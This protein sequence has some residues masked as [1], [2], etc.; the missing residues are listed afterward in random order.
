MKLSRTLWG[1]WAWKPFC[2]PHFLFIGN[3]LP[4]PW[5]SLSPKGQ[6]QRVANRDG[7]GCR[8]KRLAAKKQQCRLGAGSWLCLKE[9]TWYLWTCLQNWKF[10]QM[11]DVNLMKHSFQKEGHSLITSRT[12]DAYQETTWGQIKEMQWKWK[13]LSPVWL[14]DPMDCSL[15]GSSVHGILQARILEWVAVPFCRGPS[16]PRSLSLQVDSLPSEPDPTQTLMLISNLPRPQP[17]Q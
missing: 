2:V 15:P 13:L 16:Q 10:Q 3:R 8:G 17:L 6:V 11:E 5:P 12:R 4:P 1:S 14:C 9:Y 7:R